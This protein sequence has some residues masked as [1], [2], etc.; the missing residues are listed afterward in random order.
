LGERIKFC[1]EALNLPPPFIVVASRDY[2]SEE[3]GDLMFIY[4][5]LVR[6]LDGAA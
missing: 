1:P 4:Y 2:L 3:D 6:G 5:C